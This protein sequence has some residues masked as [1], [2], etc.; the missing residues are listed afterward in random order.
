MKKLKLD[1]SRFGDRMDQ[2]IS[3]KLIGMMKTKFVYTMNLRE[4]Q[5]TI[6][7]VLGNRIN[8][9]P[10][11]KTGEL[12]FAESRSY[13]IHE[14][15][16]HLD[17]Y[18]GIPILIHNTTM[19]ENS[20]DSTTAWTQ[21]YLSTFRTERNIKLAKEYI[22]K[23]YKKALKL[24]KKEWTNEAMYYNGRYLSYVYREHHRSFD[25]DIFLDTNIKNEIKSSI[26]NFIQKR[27]WYFEHKIPYHF[28]ILLYSEPGKG[29]SS[30]AEAIANYAN[31]KQIIVTG[32]DI[33]SL[34]N[35]YDGNIRR[36]SKNQLQCII[37]E[38]ID[39]G[40]NTNGLKVFH[41]NNDID[42]SELRKKMRSNGMAQLLNSLD[43]VNAPQDTIYIFTTNHIDRLDPALI[44]PGRIDLKV[45]IDDISLD[46]LNQF[47]NKFFDRSIDESMITQSDIP[48]D[49][50]FA[51]LQTEV[52]KGKSFEE[53]IEYIKEKGNESFGSSES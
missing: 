20:N 52:M 5:E 33:M 50:T 4:I 38:D 28:G 12:A 26:D 24:S 43:G 49:L 47:F 30:I 14:Q 35:W 46:A 6:T 16:C 17:W 53:V 11:I 51:A 7:Y 42:T 39:V 37:V 22:H 45:K 8:D 23:L 3:T 1:I 18:K 27:D 25:E 13:D 10:S 21:L 19:Y 40:F 41:T 36:I 32:D 48:G 34:S 9:Y 2:M 29:K 31:A 44:R 15:I